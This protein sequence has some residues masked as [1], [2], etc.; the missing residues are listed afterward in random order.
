MAVRRLP[1]LLDA[2]MREMTRL[3]PDALWLEERLTPV[4]CAEMVLGPEEPELPV[5]SWVSLYTAHGAAGVFRV[6]GVT[7]DGSGTRTASLMH[8]F[9][10]L[11]DEVVADDP[12]ADGP[13]PADVLLR[14]LLSGSALWRLDQCE[15]TETVHVITAGCDLLEAVL[16]VSAALPDSRWVLDQTA[17]PWRA[18]LIRMDS[19]ETAACELRLDR[20]I[21]SL[22]VTVD[23][24][25]LATRLYLTGAD[26]LTMAAANGG[27]PYVE[28]HTAEWGVV[29]AAEA[30]PLIDDPAELKRLALVRLHARSTPAV[31]VTIDG[32][33]LCEATGAA[34]DELT[35]GRM[36]RVPLPEQGRVLTERITALR[37]PDLVTDPTRVTVTLAASPRSMT[38]LAG[39][40]RARERAAQ[41]TVTRCYA[42]VTGLNTVVRDQVI[43]MEALGERVTTA[44]TG[45]AQSAYAIDLW[46]GKVT[47]YAGQTEA[48]QASVTIAAEGV[49][50][51][52]RRTEKVEGRLMTAEASL[53]VQAEQIESKVSAGDIASTINQTAQRVSISASKIDLTGYVTASQ[54]SATNASISNLTGGVTQAASLKATAINAVTGF[55]YQNHACKFNTVTIGGTTYHLLGY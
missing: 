23:R 7:T 27:V 39:A 11:A 44:E 37:W 48:L 40:Q 3:H 45:I 25:D 34:L 49:T 10:A 1:G 53:T 5:G 50:A 14:R 2:G 21:D 15:Y 16:A 6:E 20:S 42:A 31:R 51:L 46:A 47:E 19:G 29:S 36:C 26:G 30:E 22:R 35:P 12:A 4:S 33:E 24:T 38:G 52:A 28:E 8:G 41:R 13:L 43:T 17:L 18:S 9:A 55:T 32:A 54:L